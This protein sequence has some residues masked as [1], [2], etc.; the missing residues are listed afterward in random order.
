MMFK[1]K[2]KTLYGDSLDHFIESIH[3]NDSNRKEFLQ[4]IKSSLKITK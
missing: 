3:S 4:P 2:N 1:E